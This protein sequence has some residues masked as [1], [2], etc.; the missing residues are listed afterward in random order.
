VE[1]DDFCEEVQDVGCAQTD[2]QLT[3]ERLLF[4]RTGTEMEWY[5]IWYGIRRKGKELVQH[6]TCCFGINHF[7]HLSDHHLYMVDVVS[8]VGQ[9]LEP[10]LHASENIG[11]NANMQ[12]SAFR[13][14]LQRKR[15]QFYDKQ[16]QLEL[17]L[18]AQRLLETRGHDAP[19]ESGDEREECET[20]SGNS[21]IWGDSIYM[22]LLQTGVLPV[23]VDPL[24]S[25]RTR[26]RVLNYQ[27]QG[28]SLYFRDR[29][30]P[31]PKD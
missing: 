31:R 28:Q 15:P 8:E 23:A 21:D 26:K 16:Q 6:Q 17:A 18:E 24:E 14:S 22:E 4:I 19:S 30:V 2:A 3:E 13:S 20:G 25:K 7:T 11:E 29:L 5:G 12:V 27:W 10:V 1:D 9:P